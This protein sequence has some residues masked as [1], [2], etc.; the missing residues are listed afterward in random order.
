MCQCIVGEGRVVLYLG[1]LLRYLIS[2]TRIEQ[3]NALFPS[4]KFAKMKFKNLIEMELQSK[5]TP[6]LF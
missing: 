1:D 2:A 5:R 4:E 6:I 3:L